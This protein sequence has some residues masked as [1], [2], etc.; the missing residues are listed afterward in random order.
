MCRMDDL[1]L[2]TVKPN[3]AKLAAGLHTELADIHDSLP[4]GREL[5]VGAGREPSPPAEPAM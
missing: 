2:D 5:L 4:G 1:L 3:V